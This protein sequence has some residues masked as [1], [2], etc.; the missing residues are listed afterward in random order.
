MRDLTDYAC[1]GASKLE[2]RL[3]I[4]DAAQLLEFIVDANTPAAHT[5]GLAL[6]GAFVGERGAIESDPH[7]VRQIVTNLVTNAIKYTDAGHIEVYFA[8]TE[9]RLD[10]SVTDTGPGIACEQLP[11]I[12]REF[13]QLDSSSTR[14]VEGAGIG[15]AVVRGLVELLGGTI[16]VSSEVGWGTTFRVSLPTKKPPRRCCASRA[17]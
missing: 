15:L 12:F 14:H 11:L 9:Q 3:S 16:D 13:T 10:I 1:L 7:R 2:P 5:K 6:S 8:R 17:C 4:F